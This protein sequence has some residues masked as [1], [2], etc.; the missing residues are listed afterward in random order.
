M[1]STW[2]ARVNE[3]EARPRHPLA[4]SSSLVKPMTSA[5]TWTLTWVWR[6]YAMRK[7][8]VWGGGHFVLDFHTRC[9]SQWLEWLWSMC[10]DLDICNTR[11]F[12]LQD[13]LCWGRGKR[14]DGSNSSTTPSNCHISPSNALLCIPLQSTSHSVLTNVSSVKPVTN[15]EGRSWRT[16]RD[17]KVDRGGW[18]CSVVTP[19]SHHPDNLFPRNQCR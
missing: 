8:P 5:H 13:W 10:D 19:Y 17:R 14:S 15:C 1:N 4:S 12:R 7:P 16:E 9:M 2:H 6:H 11:L 3:E 18:S